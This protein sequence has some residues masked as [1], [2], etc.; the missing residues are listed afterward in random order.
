[1][2]GFVR[3]TISNAKE[4]GNVDM[5]ENVAKSSSGKNRTMLTLGISGK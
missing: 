2:K 1:L 5:N 4:T 3:W